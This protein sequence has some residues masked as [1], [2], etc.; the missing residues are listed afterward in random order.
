MKTCVYCGEEIKPGES[1]HQEFHVECFWRGILG[2][3]GH[4]RKQCSCYGGTEGDPAG[5][6]LRMAAKAAIMEYAKFLEEQ[7]HEIVAGSP[8]DRVRRCADTAAAA[9]ADDPAAKPDD[10]N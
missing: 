10:H 9:G 3:V 1:V 7:G 2:S 5:M 4:I 8:L 6:T